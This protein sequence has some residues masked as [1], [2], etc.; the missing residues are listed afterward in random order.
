MSTV[1]AD[2]ATFHVRFKQ[3]DD[4]D[5]CLEHLLVRRQFFELRCLTVNG[6][7]PLHLQRFHTVDRLADNVHHASLDLLSCGHDDRAACRYD[8]KTALQ[9][10]GIVHS[11][12]A[13]GILP[14][15]LLYLD[16]QILPVRTLYAQGIV[17]LRQNLFRILS[18]GIK[19]YID[20]RTDNLG[21]MPINL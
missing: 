9:P 5:A 13:H 8:L 1:L 4:L 17:N 21:D 10:F 2:L 20:N 14:D 16:D 12:T 3:V 11:H 15:V 7:S 19:E 6:I 18:L